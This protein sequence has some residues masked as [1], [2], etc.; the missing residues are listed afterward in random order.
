MSEMTRLIKLRP[1]PGDVIRIEASESERAD[2]AKRFGLA[3][4]QSLIA[5]VSLEPDGKAVRAAGTLAAQFM[6]ICAVS[7]EEFPV[8]VCEELALRFVEEQTS[9]TDGGAGE[10]IEIELDGDDLDEIEYTGDSFDLGEAIAQ[11]L[12][13][14]IDPYATG[15]DADAARA[16]AGITG[17][18]APQGP[19]AEALANFSPKG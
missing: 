2:L 7:A 3:S 6:Q 8:E 10:D 11:T 19:L 1:L 5:K 15:P 18:D 16:K 4:L 9:A 17:D 14:A 12:G 13:L